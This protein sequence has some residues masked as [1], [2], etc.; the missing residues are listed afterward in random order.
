[1]GCYQKK[2]SVFTFRNVSH[3]L[4]GLNLHV[5]TGGRKLKSYSNK[6]TSPS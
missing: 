2:K 1:M 4:K 5:P 6:L 3:I